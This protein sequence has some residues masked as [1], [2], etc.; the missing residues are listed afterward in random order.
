MSKV[1]EQP[2]KASAPSVTRSKSSQDV[3]AR[4]MFCS[5]CSILESEPVAIAGARTRLPLRL[6][7]TNISSRETQ[8]FASVVNTQNQRQGAY[9]VGEKIPDA[10]V[11]QYIGQDYVDFK[12]E[13]SEALE[14]MNFDSANVAAKQPTKRASASTNALASEYVRSISD[15]H[16]E[17]DRDL[18]GKL[19]SSPKLAGARAMPIHKN[20][21]MVGVRLSGVRSKGLAYSMGL[22]NGDRVLAAN[23]VKLKSL[24]ASLE[25]LGQ[26]K[27]RDHWSIEIERRGKSIQLQVDLQ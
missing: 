11:V 9:R 8:S 20:G 24:E 25:L 6:I 23:G 16:F 5:T 22:R 15:T 13:G 12:V 14:R 26:L 7:A 18:I 3:V 21:S 17:V 10:G 19:Q 4:N 2:T 1:R 27:S